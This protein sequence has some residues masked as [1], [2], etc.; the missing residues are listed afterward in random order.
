MR[1]VQYL[2]SLLFAAV[3][4]VIS[5]SAFAQIGISVEFGPPAACL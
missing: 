3:L 1:V 4:V 5:T 2:R